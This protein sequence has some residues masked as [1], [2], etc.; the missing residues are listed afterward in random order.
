MFGGAAETNVAAVHAGVLEPYLSPSFAGI[1][2]KYTS[3]TKSRGCPWRR[4]P[5][6][7]RS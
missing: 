7:R 1:P 6:T 4:A 3:G 5:L 2:A